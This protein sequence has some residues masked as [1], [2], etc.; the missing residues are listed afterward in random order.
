VALAVMTVGV[1]RLTR[2]APQDLTPSKP[3]GSAQD[4]V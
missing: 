1:V 4:P 2:T 3:A